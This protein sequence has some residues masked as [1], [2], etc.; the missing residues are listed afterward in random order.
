M[1]QHFAAQF[2]QLLKRWMRDVQPGT[3]VE[4]NWAHS[5]DECQL[6]GLQF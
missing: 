5:V 6:Q 4:G 3:V 2:V 1:K